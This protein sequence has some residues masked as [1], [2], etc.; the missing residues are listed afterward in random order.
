MK[1]SVG[2]GAILLILSGFVCKIFGAFFRLPLTNILGIEG[3]GVFQ[4][5]MSIYSL[6]LILVTGGVTSSLSKLV[7]SARAKGDVGKINGYFRLALLFSAGLSLVL[8]LVFA[9]FSKQISSVQG[10][11]EGS[12]SYMLLAFLLPLGALIGVYRGIIQGYENMVPTAVSQIIEQAIKFALGLF[13]AKLL[14]TNNLSSGVFGAFLGITAGE[15]LAFLYLGIVMILKYKVKAERMP[16]ARDFFKAVLPLTAGGAIIPFSHAIDS[17][18]VVSL[19]VKAG[20]EQTVATTLYGLQTG[21]VGALLNFPLIISLSVGTSLLPKVSYLTSRSDSVGQKA[22][23]SKSFSLLWLALLP[24][25][26]GIMSIAE[27]IYPFLYPNLMTG[28]LD[29][30]VKL[31]F[32]GA[33]SVILTAIMQ[34]LL[35]LLQAKGKYLFSMIAMLFA[36]AIK[37]F[38]VFTLT[39]QKNVNIFAIPLSNIFLAGTFA[40]LAIIKLKGLL[41]LPL[42]NFFLPLLSA[43]IMFMIVKILLTLFNNV[44]G[45]IFA[46]V[47]GA[48]VYLALSSPLIIEFFKGLLKNKRQKEETK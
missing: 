40:I 29:Y 14:V 18:F 41:H 23:I 2:K 12:Y 19:L 4:M 42:F 5:V 24:L 11:V 46:V 33:V 26:F 3:I 28:Y 45:L 25:V 9:F 48:V 36:S 16:V 38:L 17:L 22:I 35:S 31:T 8:G 1:N 30:A 7:S 44:W 15:L 21:V 37:I 27:F 34:F 10:A 43:F 13:F 39:V 20:L 47:V 6:A 32:I